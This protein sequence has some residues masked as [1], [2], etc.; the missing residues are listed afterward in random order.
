VELHLPEQDIGRAW[1]KFASTER[2]QGLLNRDIAVIDLRLPD[3]LVVR[4][5]PDVERPKPDT[6]RKGRG[7]ET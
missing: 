7:K 6:T 1:A 5:S 2:S 3:R 4:L